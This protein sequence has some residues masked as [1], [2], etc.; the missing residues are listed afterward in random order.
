MKLYLIRH[1]QT[2]ANITYTYA[3]ITDSPLSDAGIEL[4]KK[5]HEKGGYPDISKLD[6]YT[7]GLT[8]TEQTLELLF[9]QVPHTKDPDFMEMNFGIFEGKTYDEIKDT[10]AYQAWV[11]RDHMTQRCPG[12]EN[13]NEML[14]RILRGIK[15]ITEKGRDALIVTHGGVI[16]MLFTYY[17]PGTGLTWYEIQP[18][19]GEGY[20]FEFEGDR[21]VSY[22]KI[23][24]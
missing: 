7:S 3:G 6:V 20:I 12:G 22:S 18:A 8:R 15:R 13:G 1:G 24:V 2:M 11:T 10:E 17:F 21:A 23:P 16:A 14:E 9:G 4:L 5:Q 19:N